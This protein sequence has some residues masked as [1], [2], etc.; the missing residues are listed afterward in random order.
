MYVTKKAVLIYLVKNEGRSLPYDMIADFA[1]VTPRT[2]FTC[3]QG[4]ISEGVVSR[5]RPHAGATYRY[6]VDR[7]LAGE[8]Y[9]VD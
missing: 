4:L 5:F 9:D 2:A 7:L 3:L 1:G 8:L 6:C